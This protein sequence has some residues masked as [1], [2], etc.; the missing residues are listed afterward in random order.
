MTE[1]NLLGAEVSQ[2][3]NRRDEGLR[4]SLVDLPGAGLAV[5]AGCQT[6]NASVDSS[7]VIIG[8]R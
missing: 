6:T 8:A 5:L 3:A 7:M 2:E 1:R 4:I